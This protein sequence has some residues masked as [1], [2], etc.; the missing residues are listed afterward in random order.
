[1]DAVIDRQKNHGMHFWVLAKELRMSGGDHSHA[2]TIAGIIHVWHIPALI[3]IFGNNSVLQ[4]GGGTL[5]HPWGN[6][7]GVVANRVALEACVKAH[8]EGRDLA[9]EGN[10]IIHEASKWSPERPAA[11]EVCKEIVFNFAAVDVLDK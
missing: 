1:M 7:P 10:K 5:G 8:N 3:E 11:C 4:F 6:V 9:W 2:G